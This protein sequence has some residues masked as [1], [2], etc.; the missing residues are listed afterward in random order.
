MGVPQDLF[1]GFCLSLGF[2]RLRVQD[3]GI[4]NLDRVVGY[5]ERTIGKFITKC[6]EPYMG[7]SESTEP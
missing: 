4:D 7:A 3:G 2:Y 6:S 1:L 5:V